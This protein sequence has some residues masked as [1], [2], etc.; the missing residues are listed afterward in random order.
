VYP[1][2]GEISERDLQWGDENTTKESFLPVGKGKRS[3]SFV[4]S[5]EKGDTLDISVQAEERG[6]FQQR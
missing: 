1:S 3:L 2:I 4:V 6:A 5:I